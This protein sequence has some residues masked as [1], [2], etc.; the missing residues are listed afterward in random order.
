MFYL[1][2]NCIEDKFYTTK[3]MIRKCTFCSFRFFKNSCLD[4]EFAELS[5]FDNFNIF[6]SGNHL[7]IQNFINT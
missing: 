7:I 2:V 6:Y 4:K 3:S 5:D 1:Y